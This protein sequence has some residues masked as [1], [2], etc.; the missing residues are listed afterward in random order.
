MSLYQC[1]KCGCVENTALGHYHCRN[2]KEMWA[3]EYIG[4][5]L[6][7]ECGPAEY[8]DGEKCRDLGKWHGRFEKII[9]PL[10]SLY[11]DKEGNVRRKSD[12]KHP[13]EKE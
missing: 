6:C 4:K 13:S 2:A 8:K 5:S 3:D 9:Y 1:E 12:D 10:G 11:T 7:S